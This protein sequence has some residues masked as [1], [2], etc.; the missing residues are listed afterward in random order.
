MSLVIRAATPADADAVHALCL[1]FD[2]LADEVTRADFDSRFAFMV[3]SD[4]FF[5]PVAELDGELVGYAQAQDYGRNLRTTFAVGRM[6]DLFVL[7]THRGAGV[8]RALMRA[9]GEWAR[10]R[11]HALILD[12]QSRL[13]AVGFYEALGFEADHHGD[14]AEYPGFC[15]DTRDDDAA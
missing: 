10:S 1:A 8:A 14:Y 5:L 9:M 12:W 4:D 2:P 3:G 13:G 11:P 7:E 6:D 15:I